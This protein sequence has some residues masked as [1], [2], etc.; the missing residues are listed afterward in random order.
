MIY[1]KKYGRWFNS[2]QEL[3]RFDWWMRRTKPILSWGGLRDSCYS[4]EWLAEH[5]PPVQHLSSANWA[6]VVGLS[7]ALFLLLNMCSN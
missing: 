1:S 4:K 3:G 6:W 2:R 7:V 5:R